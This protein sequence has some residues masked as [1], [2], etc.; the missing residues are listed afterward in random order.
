MA[1]SNLTEE[2]K[3][4]LILLRRYVTDSAN[5]GRVRESIIEDLVRTQGLSEDSATEITDSVLDAPRES[6]SNDGGRDMIM[7]AIICFIGILI[8]IGTASAAR[9][10]GTYVVA[11]GAIIVGAIQF[12]RGLINLMGE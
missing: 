6:R 11:Y 1:D 3:Q 5:R 9:S 7:G 8:T 4:R 10:G 12:L 2:Q